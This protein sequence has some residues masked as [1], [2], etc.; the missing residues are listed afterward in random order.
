MC[1][2]DTQTGIPVG[3][4]Y[5]TSENLMART[6]LDNPVVSRRSCKQR[7]P[8]KKSLLVQ[9]PHCKRGILF[10]SRQIPHPW[11]RLPTRK[12]MLAVLRAIFFFWT[13]AHRITVLWWSC[14]IAIYLWH[15]EPSSN[16]NS[17]EKHSF[18]LWTRPILCVIVGSGSLC[19]TQYR[20]H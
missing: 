7:I 5:V 17:V 3:I 9:N 12:I 10:Y 19:K 11:S 4:F 15:L 1:M 18:E 14:K 6:K 8:S 20:G 2:V 16:D 13:S